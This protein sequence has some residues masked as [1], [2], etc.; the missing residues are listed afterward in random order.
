MSMLLALDEG[1]SSCRTVAFDLDGNIKAVSQQ[2]FRQHYPRPGWVEHDASEI[3]DRQ[4]Q[5]LSAV[6][7]QLDGGERDVCGVGITNQRETVVVWDRRTGEPI[8]RAIVWQDRRTAAAMAHLAE[9]SSIRELVRTRTGLVLD[10]Y[11]SASKL[12]WMLDH[13][14]GARAAADAGHLAFG[15]IECWLLWCLT[16]GKQH[17]TDASNAARTMLFDINAQCWDDELLRLF[18]IPASLLP[19]VV[20]CAGSFGAIDAIDGLEV[21]GLIGDQQSALFG[22]GS[23]QPGDAKTTF[24]TGCFL[25]MNTGGEAVSSDRGLLSTVAWRLGGESTWALEGSVFMGGASIQWLRDGLGII[26]AAPDVNALAGSVDDSDGVILVPAFAGLGAPHWDAWGRAAILGM[27]RGTTAAHIA[28]AT[29]E[30]IALSVR[31]V[32]RAMEADSGISLHELRV[33]GGAAA[34]DLLMQI[35]ADVLDTAVLRPAML[36]TTAWGAASM[37]GIGA[38]VYA[39]P[40][41]AAGHWHLDKRF[42]SA[43]DPARRDRKLRAWDRAVNSVRGWARDDDEQN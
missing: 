38:G 33:D 19:E 5:T 36:E 18:D 26:D 6:L 32:L 22:Q 4:L 24:G 42:E 8:H 14:D 28:R 13:V 27:T 31:D 37:A 29:L 12:Q 1:T 41:D 3:R 7:G 16:G 20:D 17:V 40:E 15:T 11:F 25:L 39:S 21:N 30:G 35:Q 2:E 23:L 34:S 43:V 10:P 9:D